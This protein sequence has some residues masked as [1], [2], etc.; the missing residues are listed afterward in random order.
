MQL[1]RSPVGPWG[2]KIDLVPHTGIAVFGKEWPHFVGLRKLREQFHT[3]LFLLL[4]VQT[5][6]CTARS[7]A[8]HCAP[9][10]S[11]LCHIPWLDRCNT[12]IRLIYMFYEADPDLPAMSM[13]SL[14]LFLS[15]ICHIGRGTSSVEVHRLEFLGNQCPSMR[16]GWGVVALSCFV[17]PF[18]L[19]SQTI[20]KGKGIA[21]YSA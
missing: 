4:A 18:F 13:E 2:K 17:N 3:V 20:N 6:I 21:Y 15:F 9:L 12:S 5:V 1:A 16:R 8:H 11:V 19:Q 7:Y 14:R 10:D